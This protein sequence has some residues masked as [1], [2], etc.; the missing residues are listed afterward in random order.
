MNAK[1]TLI[2]KGPQPIDLILSFSIWL[3]LSVCSQAS[4]LNLVRLIDMRLSLVFLTTTSDSLGIMQKVG[5]NIK[6]KILRVFIC[7]KNSSCI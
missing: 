4:E 6:P 1:D 5:K 2:Q 7:Y 3:Y